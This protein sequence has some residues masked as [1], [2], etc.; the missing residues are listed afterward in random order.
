M[1]GVRVLASG[2][3]E[4]VERN[5]TSRTTIDAVPLPVRLFGVV[6]RGLLVRG[7]A[8]LGVRFDVVERH[9]GGYVLVG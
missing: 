9:G 4:R 6:P 3:N 5:E 8:V 7:G 2:N 1:V